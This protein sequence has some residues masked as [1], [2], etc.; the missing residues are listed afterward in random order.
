MNIQLRQIIEGKLY[1]VYGINI[2]IA[3]KGNEILIQGSMTHI[4][5]LQI[6]TFILGFLNGWQSHKE[7]DCFKLK[8]HRID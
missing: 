5:E 6:H 8:I 2:A 4:E 1:E 3:S 7:K